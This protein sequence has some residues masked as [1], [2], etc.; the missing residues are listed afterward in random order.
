MADSDIE[1]SIDDIKLG[2]KEARAFATNFYK[3]RFK[4]GHLLSKLKVVTKDVQSRP[5]EYFEVKLYELNNYFTNQLQGEIHPFQSILEFHHIYQLM[6]NIELAVPE[7]RDKVLSA[8]E[9][10]IANTPTVE[11]EYLFMRD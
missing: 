1:D 9:N 4:E 10:A 6:R 3:P 7:K 8:R 2:K 5:I 11:T